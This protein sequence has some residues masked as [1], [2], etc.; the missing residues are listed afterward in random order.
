MQDHAW[1]LDIT[2][3][4][5]EWYS[6]ESGQLEHNGLQLKYVNEDNG[7][8]ILLSNDNSLYMNVIVINFDDD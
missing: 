3:S 2:E 1:K 8:S 4:V 5:K 6:D 7:N